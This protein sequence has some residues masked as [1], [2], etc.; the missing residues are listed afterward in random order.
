MPMSSTSF[1]NIVRGQL[2]TSAHLPD[3]ANHN[4]KDL[5]KIRKSL[6]IVYGCNEYEPVISEIRIPR[7]CVI[8]STRLL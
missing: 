7:Q 5:H 3:A 4:K 2:L 1:V 6:E 8:V